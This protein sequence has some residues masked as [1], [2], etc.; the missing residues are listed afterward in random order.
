[1]QPSSS[2]FAGGTSPV[3]PAVPVVPVVPASAAAAYDPGMSARDPS[4]TQT[5][6]LSAEA[7]REL[8]HPVPGLVLVFSAGK[9]HD[10]AIPLVAGSLTVGRGETT[11]ALIE[12]ACLSRKHG[13]VHFDGGSFV[14]RDLGSR[15]GSS[16]DGERIPAGGTTKVARVLRMGDSIFLPL[17]DL[18]PFL[19][20][21]PVH[22]SD[23]WVA[24]PALQRAY[25]RIAQ[26]ARF[27]DTL[28][29]AGESGVGKEGAARAFHQ[30]GPRAGG[31][32]IAVNCAAIPEGVA[33]RLLFGAQRGAYSGATGDT[34]GYVQ[35]AD[36]GTL[37]LDELA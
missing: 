4:R 14:V 25:E 29:I 21:R 10:V 2:P 11:A 28:H 8:E 5:A 3:V 22:V 37:F 13:E 20:A 1:M 6:S 31:P 17:A 26:A 19:C 27:D 24:G 7:A 34:K 12:D 18:R 33:E 16:A 30:H 35:A 9:P 23:G 15:N 32:F 36:G